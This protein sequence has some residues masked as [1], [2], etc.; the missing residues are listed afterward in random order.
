[1]SKEFSPIERR[2]FLGGAALS[3]SGSIPGGG[4]SSAAASE[5]SKADQPEDAS[6][7]KRLA[8]TVTE[9]R[10]RVAKV[11]QFS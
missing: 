2:T 7:K 8:F 10:A 3:A 1:M 9:Y 4:T 11:Q 6:A 5:K